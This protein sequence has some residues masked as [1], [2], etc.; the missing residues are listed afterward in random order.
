M[1]LFIARANLHLFFFEK[2]QKAFAF[3]FIEKVEELQRF[4]PPRR[5]LKESKITSV[6]IPG[7]R[8]D[9]TQSGGT[10]TGPKGGFC[11]DCSYQAMNG[12]TDTVEDA[13]VAMLP[14]EPGD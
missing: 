9:V 2:S 12:G 7:R 6:D 14:D 13:A 11:L 4:R 3:H 10:G 5:V 8:D 1:L